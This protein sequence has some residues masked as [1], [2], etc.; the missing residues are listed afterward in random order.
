MTYS[1]APASNTYVTITGDDIRDCFL[2]KIGREPCCV[3]CSAGLV[4]LVGGS[5]AADLCV[6]CNT[7]YVRFESGWRLHMRVP[8]ACPAHVHWQRCG[9]RYTRDA[10]PVC[11]NWEQPM[12]MY[13]A[14]VLGTDTPSGKDGRIIQLP[15]KR[16]V[17]AAPTIAEPKIWI[18]RQPARASSWPVQHKELRQ[19]YQ[20]QMTW[21]I[22]G[23]YQ[24][25]IT[26]NC[27]KQVSDWKL[28]KV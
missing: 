8:D 15:K 5:Y 4:C 22:S 6:K 9:N 26:E 10:C 25:V 18:P 7:R 2:K 3:G 16:V 1:Y 11:K 21:E 19:E 12:H 20:N 27:I 28:V 17:H 24:F 23:N 14:W 13:G